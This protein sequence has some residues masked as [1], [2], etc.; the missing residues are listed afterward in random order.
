MVLYLKV[1]KIMSGI[2]NRR[3]TVILL[4]FIVA[5]LAVL[6]M[7]GNLIDFQVSLPE[8]NTTS[9]ADYGKNLILEQSKINLLPK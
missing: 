9:I 7:N 6:Y 5:V 8:I 2:L 3:N 1:R 4:G